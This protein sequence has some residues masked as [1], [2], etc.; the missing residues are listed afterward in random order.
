[1][2]CFFTFRGVV[3]CNFHFFLSLWK[4]ETI[5]TVKT[6]NNNQQKDP[7]Q[8]QIEL[9]PEVAE[10]VYANLAVL[11]HSSAEFI[12]DFIRVLPGSPK[13]PVKSRV[14]MAPEHAKR[15]L[16]ALQNNISKYESAFGPIRIPEMQGRP[17]KPSDIYMGDA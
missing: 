8:L 15:L 1:M 2:P 12:F 16:L 10:G 7:N 14:I 6:M 11:T 9:T 13:A 3:L 5:K 17:Q 4:I